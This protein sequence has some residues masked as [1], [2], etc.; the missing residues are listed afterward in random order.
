VCGECGAA[1]GQFEALEFKFEAFYE[2]D[3]GCG[4]GG[5]WRAALSGV[6]EQSYMEEE[7]G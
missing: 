5:V 7:L 3:G 4:P 2:G 6:K 1:F